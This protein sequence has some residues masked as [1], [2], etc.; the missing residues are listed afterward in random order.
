VFDL[1]ELPGRI[2]VLGAGPVGCE[3]AQA[4]ARF[5]SRVTVIDLSDRP[6]PREEPEASA[7]LLSALAADGVDFHGG[8]RI[9]RVRRT[10]GSAAEVWFEKGPQRRSLEVDALLVATGRVPNTDLGLDQ[11]GVAFDAS[12]VKVDD[13]LRTSNR[14]IYAVGDVASDL[15][16]THLADAQ[17]RIAV[18]NALFFGRAK[19]SSLIVPMATYTCPEVARVGPTAT[20]LHAK[21]LA[22]DTVTVP[23]QDVDRARLDGEESGLAQILLRRGTD[24]ILGATVVAARAG[25]LISQLVQAMTL[26]MGLGALGEVIFPYPTTAEVL[27]K[28]ADQHRRRKLTPRVRRFFDLFLRATRLLP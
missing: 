14:R 11:A 18:R 7:I 4:F 27:R 24:E 23:L 6:L 26:K 16:F 17:A 22:I 20:E 2:L 12:G 5:G 9:T 25:D 10:A 13:R 8:A 15:K 21:G 1:L 3:L 19:A 28:A